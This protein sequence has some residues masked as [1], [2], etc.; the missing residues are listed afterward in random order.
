MTMRIPA[1]LLAAAC[2]FAADNA[3]IVTYSQAMAGDDAYAKRDA[4]QAL[5][6]KA[7]GSDDDI[8]PLLVKAVGDRQASGYAVQALRS[9]TGLTPPSGKTT[10][11]YPGYPNSDSSA[12]WGA[13]LAARARDQELKKKLDSLEQ[14]VDSKDGSAKTDEKKDEAAAEGQAQSEPAPAPRIPTDDL[15]KPDRIIYKSGRSLIA[16]V[17]SKRLDAEGNLVSVRVV[18]NDGAG[19]EVIDA[20]TISRIEEDVE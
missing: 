19:E 2:A 5:A 4:I 10:S 9:R 14:K 16:Y 18:H 15:G 11:A 3:A 17:R 7:S 20:S 12:D 8:L 1:L 6:N 13:W